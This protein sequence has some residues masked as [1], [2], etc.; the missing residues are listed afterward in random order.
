MDG[1]PSDVSGYPGAYFT[2]ALV[3]TA[4]INQYRSRRVFIDNGSS[5]DIM[6]EK[7]FHQLDPEDQTQLEEVDAPVFGF[8]GDTV[9]PIG[10]ISFP[11]TLGTGIKTRT[12]KLT[13]LVLPVCSRHNIIIGRL[14]LATFN[15]LPS[16]IH[17]AI[18]LPTP[19]GVAIV[20][21]DKD[22]ILT[23]PEEDTK[24]KGLNP[25]KWNPGSNCHHWSE[26]FRQISRPL[27]ADA[28]AECR[29]FR[30][31]AL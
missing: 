5:T 27:E 18:G 24:Q 6:Y 9:H 28:S 26:N 29:R 14:G 3:I 23:E 30:L 8:S 2:D 15:A 21:A 13:F 11:V 31:T 20:Y 16:T 7:R 17:G 25:E 22:C 12:E 19:K 4:Y 1:R 10:Q